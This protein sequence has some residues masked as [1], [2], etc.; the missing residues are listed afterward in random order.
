MFLIGMRTSFLFSIA[1]WKTLSIC[2]LDDLASLTE[3]KYK[4][5]ASKLRFF[6]K[7]LARDTCF[8]FMLF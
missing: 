5:I 3:E 8:N 4:V 7:E 6:S 1:S 2:S